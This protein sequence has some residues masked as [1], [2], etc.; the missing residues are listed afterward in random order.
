MLTKHCAGH[1]IDR[2]VPVLVG[3]GVLADPKAIAHDV[4]VGEVED[5]VVKVDVTD[6]QCAQLA[7]PCAGDRDQP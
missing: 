6:L 4:G 2:E 7:S 3:L 1:R 5:A